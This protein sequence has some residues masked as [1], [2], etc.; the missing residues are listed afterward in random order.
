VD[1]ATRA[2]DLPGGFGAG[3]S[4]AD[5]SHIRLHRFENL[6]EPEDAKALEAA[7]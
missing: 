1:P 6:L 2:G 3:Q 7:T 5:Y 4:A